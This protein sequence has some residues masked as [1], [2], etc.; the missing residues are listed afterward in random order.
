MKKESSEPIV[1]E[2]AI[3]GG[4][5]IGLELAA[6]LAEVGM[7]YRLLEAH[8]IG[9]TIST[10]PR[11]THFYS[12]AERIAIAGVPIPIVD[13]EHITGEQYMAYLR[14]VAQQFDLRI[15]AYERV[16]AVKPIDGTLRLRTETCTGEHEYE[17]QHVVLATGDM[18]AANRLGIP[19]ESLSHVSHHPDDPHRYFG[20]R[21]LVVGGGNSALEF[22]ARCWRAGA[23]V[24]L[25]YRR[26]SFN[27]LFVKSRLME[28]FRTLTREGKIA[29]LPRTTPV[30][31]GPTSV[32]LAPTRS[33]E[34]VDGERLEHP[35]DFVLLCTGYVADLSLFEQAGVTI[36]RP[37]GRV[38]RFDPDTMETDVPGLYVAGT[39]ANGQQAR[40]KLFI[41]TSHHH[42]TRILEDIS[43]RTPTRVN[44]LV[45]KGPE[46][47]SH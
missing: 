45:P 15:N 17:S 22:A 41:E 4:G 9:H 47:L 19:G 6:A 39:A 46:D 26:A 13:H 28:D 14:A 29:F 8:Q 36:E 24:T 25:S 16:T 23:E 1:T 27:P 5:P 34:P 38:P 42:V 44:R 18:S 33:G 30:G 11:H 35:T 37:P 7:D 31:I 40:H 2:V 3:V 12:T 10:W 43:G 21:L 20:Q 32:T